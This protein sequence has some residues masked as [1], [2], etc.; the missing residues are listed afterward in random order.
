MGGIDASGTMTGRD[1]PLTGGFNPA[2]KLLSSGSG[3]DF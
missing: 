1:I 3:S 2:E